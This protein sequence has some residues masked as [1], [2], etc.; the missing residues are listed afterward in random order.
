[1]KT[2][3]MTAP[4]AAWKTPAIRLEIEDPAEITRDHPLWLTGG[5]VRCGSA[6][7]K[8]GTVKLK[9]FTQPLEHNQWKLRLG[10]L[11]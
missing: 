1:L 4:V 5:T 9:A 3:A 11:R 8:T 2:Y 6:Q 7:L 10:P